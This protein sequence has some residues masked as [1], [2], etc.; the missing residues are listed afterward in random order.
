M[1]SLG[2]GY[3][4]GHLGPEKGTLREQFTEARGEPEG[5]VS[6]KRTISVKCVESQI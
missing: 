3:Y 1:G 5:R 4:Y 6:R 2:A